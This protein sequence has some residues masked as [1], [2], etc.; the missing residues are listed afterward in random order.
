MNFNLITVFV[1]GTGAI[2]VYSGV[3]NV[4]PKDVITNALKG[5]PTPGKPASTPAPTPSG[6]ATVVP[7]VYPSV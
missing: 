6:P 1:F 2:L 7:A 3:K 5:K 4:H